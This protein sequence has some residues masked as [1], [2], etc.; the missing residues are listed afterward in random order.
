MGSAPSLIAGGAALSLFVTP[1]AQRLLECVFW[2]ARPLGSSAVRDAIEAMAQRAGIQ[3]LALSVTERASKTPARLLGFQRGRERILFDKRFVQTSQ[4]EAVSVVAAHEIGQALGAH[5]ALK[6]LACAAGL[7]V[8][9]P[10]A[11]RF[12][13]WLSPFWSRIAW[14]ALAGA[15]L[16][17]LWLLSCWMERDADRMGAALLEA[18]SPP[19]P[20][21][22]MPCLVS[23]VFLIAAIA[24]STDITFG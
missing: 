13:L 10:A 20:S 16:A 22:A 15:V 23:A 3:R 6:L 18:R 19:R 2:R 7:L 4:P 9:G 24:W 8:A 11:R 12:E 21:K 17:F 1:L 14:I 5:A